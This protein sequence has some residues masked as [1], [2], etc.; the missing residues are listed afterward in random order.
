M[1][2]KTQIQKYTFKMDEL[3]Q[4]MM[5]HGN[6]ATGTEVEN[7]ATLVEGKT[8]SAKHFPSIYIGLW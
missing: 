7:V 8:D 2:T 5:P 4:H 3:V 1:G 6:I